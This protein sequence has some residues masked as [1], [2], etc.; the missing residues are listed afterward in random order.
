MTIERLVAR[1]GPDC[2]WCGTT[3]YPDPAH[4]GQVRTRDHLVP[5]SAGGSN[6]L[7]NQVLACP[8]CNSTRGSI[9]SDVWAWAMDQAR[10][11]PRP[12]E[13]V[14]VTALGLAMGPQVPSR[15]T[16]VA[17]RRRPSSV[18][19][20]PADPTPNTGC[21]RCGRTWNMKWPVDPCRCYGGPYGPWPPPDPR[22]EPGTF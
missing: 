11:A 6:A 22:W 8:I 4:P 7:A 10:A 2:F 20:W 19:A 9:P 13:H 18:V 16:A 12:T 3:T 15:L 17:L 1:D 5:R 14:A 21:A